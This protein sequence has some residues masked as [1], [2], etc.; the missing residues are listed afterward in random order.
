VLA[1]RGVTSILVDGVSVSHSGVPV[2]NDI[3]LSVNNAELLVIIG[4]SG[5]GESHLLRTV[6]GS[7]ASAMET[8]CSM[9]R[10]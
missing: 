10:T 3:T 1:D 6:A 7:T 5:S 9:T 2:I 8:S 4:P